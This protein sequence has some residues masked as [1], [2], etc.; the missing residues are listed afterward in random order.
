MS[1][2]EITLKAGNLVK[3]DVS[4]SGFRKIASVMLSV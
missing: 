2:V 3:A 1:Y 4:E